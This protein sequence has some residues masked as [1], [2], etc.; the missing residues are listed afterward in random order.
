MH[1][2]IHVGDSPLLTLALAALLA[3]TP[4][5]TVTAPEKDQLVCKMI[6]EPDVG[7]NIRR[8]H[9]TCMRASDWKDLDRINENAKR[10]I[11]LNPRGQPQPVQSGVGG[12]GN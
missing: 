10:K 6:R 1:S 9:K 5:I 12:N 7:S 11:F 8:R 3:S 2:P 4:D